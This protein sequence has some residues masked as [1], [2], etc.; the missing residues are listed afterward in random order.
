MTKTLLSSFAG[1]IGTSPTLATETWAASVG[2]TE[3]NMT[4][5]AGIAG[6]AGQSVEA[7]LARDFVWNTPGSH[8]RLG[9]WVNRLSGTQ[10]LGLAVILLRS[11]T[12]ARGDLFLRNQNGGQF[13]LRAG[14]GG[15]TYAG[16]ST[17]TV[18][19][20]DVWW[21]EVEYNATTMNVFLWKPGN[22]TSVPDDSFTSTTAGTVD[23]VRLFNPS[24]TTG[25][26]M[27]F[28]ELWMSDGEQI[29]VQTVATTAPGSLALSGTATRSVTVARSAAGVLALSGDSS[30]A[31][32]ITR[33]SAGMLSL[34]GAGAPALEVARTASTTLT[35]NGTAERATTVTRTAAGSLELSGV[36]S[37]TGS[38]DRTADGVLA[39][40][41]SAAA[42][43]VIARTA[44]G[45]LALGGVGAVTFQI[46]M[47]AVGIL[48]LTGV[49]VTAARVIPERLTLTEVTVS[50]KLT[51]VPVSHTLEDA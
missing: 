15:T 12:T 46:I 43:V 32:V 42:A 30:V 11:G 49:G 16:Q 38:T 14:V 29:R 3:A 5:Q 7:T 45:T 47:T 4:Y 23:N 8:W 31:T 22:V 25:M 6:T 10:I 18:A 28:G 9:M 34:T 40:Q 21:V 35:V 37:T 24:G 36:A 39:V 13:A 33:T 20:G 50:H 19:S 44:Q 48:N 41:G 1:T 51:P 2:G 27:R 17:T 26:T